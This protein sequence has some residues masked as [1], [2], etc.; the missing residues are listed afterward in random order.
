LEIN[1]AIFIKSSS[2]VTDC[3]PPNK[4]E[5]AFVGR[6]NVGKSSLLNLL[7]SQKKL[8]KISSTPGKTRLINHFLINEEWYL[9]DLPGYGYARISKKS[10]EGFIGMIELYLQKRDNLL[11][12]FVLIDSRLEPQKI[13]L[14]FIEWL[15][16]N[17]IPFVLCFTKIDKISGNMLHSNVE[18]FK[19]ELLKKWE[20]LP[21]V[22]ASSAKTKQGKE[23]ILGF[24]AKTIS[25][26][27]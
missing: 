21:P 5:F 10:R 9:T 11:C 20:S 15:G 22:F 17:R 3:P 25:G 1:E 16:I 4:P 26:N 6:S 23:E 2:N 8:A 27:R 19:K 7:T 12:L 18:K 13:D 24:I 14:E